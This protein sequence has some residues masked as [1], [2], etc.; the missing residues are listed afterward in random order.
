MHTIARVAAGTSLAFISLTLSAGDP[1]AAKA[2]VVEHCVKC[3]A[4]PG[5]D[6]AGTPALQAPDFALLADQPEV[7]TPD[8]LRRSLTQPHWPMTQF[9]LSKSDVENLLSYI[10]TL[11]SSENSAS[12]ELK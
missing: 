3:H 5:Y 8:R 4:V 10:E 1:N 9:I 12:P 11:R 7:Y 6:G 2:I